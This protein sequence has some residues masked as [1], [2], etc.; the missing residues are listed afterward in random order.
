MAVKQVD[1]PHTASDRGS[2]HQLEMVHALRRE[3][4]SLTTLVHENIIQYLG[5]HEDLHR[6]TVYVPFSRGANFGVSWCHYRFLEYVPGGSI[7]SCLHK[8]GSFAEDHTKHFMAQIIRGLE[9]LHSKHVLHRVRLYNLI[10]AVLADP[11]FQD[12]KGDNILLQQ[13]GNCKISDFGLSKRI[14]NDAHSA[15]KG[16]VFWMA[17]EVV[18]STPEKGYDFKADIWSVGC[19]LHE[20]WFNER[21]W[22][23]QNAQ[24][25]LTKVCFRKLSPYISAY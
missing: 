19:V 9:Y 8:Y 2:A 24:T 4:D 20:M 18:R 6:L 21:P 5:Y 14:E 1:I 13:T 7:T 15:I 23:G 22:A 16:T 12:L 25:V 11:K 17:P 3:I 10:L